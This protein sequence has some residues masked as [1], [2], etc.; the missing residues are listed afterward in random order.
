[1]RPR[2][3]TALANATTA[4]APNKT[5]FPALGGA[6]LQAFGPVHWLIVAAV[7]IVAAV[8][9]L[10]AGPSRERRVRGMRT[11]EYVGAGG[12]GRRPSP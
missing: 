2:T 10:A 12:G 9:H 6:S 8:L 5:R 3:D 11:A 1:M 7:G 4:N